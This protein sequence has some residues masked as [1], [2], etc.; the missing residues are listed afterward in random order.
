MVNDGRNTGRGRGDS[1][2]RTDAAQGNINP[3]NIKKTRFTVKY[4]VGEETADL[5]HYQ[6]REY[7]QHETYSF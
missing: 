3:Y 1:S 6:C 2:R 4:Y 5:N 7:S